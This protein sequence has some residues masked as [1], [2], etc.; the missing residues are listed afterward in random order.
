M[1]LDDLVRAGSLIRPGPAGS[2]PHGLRAFEPVDADPTGNLARPA[3]SLA[4][5]R[6]GQSAWLNTDG[7]TGWVLIS[8]IGAIVVGFI[9]EGDH[10]GLLEIDSA[11]GSPGGDQC[12]GNPQIKLKRIGTYAETGKLCIGNGGSAAGAQDSSFDIDFSRIT[13]V[14]QWRRNLI[15][16]P[17]AGDWAIAKVTPPATTANG[18]LIEL[19]RDGVGIYCS[20]TAPAGTLNN[21]R[22]MLIDN[23]GKIYLEFP[24]YS[25]GPHGQLIIDGTHGNN[26]FVASARNSGGELFFGCNKSTNNSDLYI[27][28]RAWAGFFG[29]AYATYLQFFTN[30]STRLTITPNGTI[31]CSGGL[32]TTATSGH[33]IFPTCAGVPTGIP[34]GGVGAAIVDSTTGKLYI[35]SGVAWVA[36]T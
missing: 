10:V 33:F 6:E 9:I 32:A 3:G 8:S 20:A 2:P 14:G 18:E 28:G 25:G 26:E 15:F 11:G 16:N 21:K 19:G 13:G 24:E 4:Y 22:R 35:W 30:S 36:Q 27:N 17:S 12:L 34:E 31:Q 5:L 7:Q 1:R 23:E 29:T